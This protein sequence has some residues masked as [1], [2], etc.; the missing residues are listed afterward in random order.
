MERGV[1]PRPEIV[2]RL[3]R[4]VLAKLWINDP[5]PAARSREWREMLEKRFGTSSIPLYVTLDGDGREIGG[6]R[7]DF[8]GGGTDAFAADLAAFLDAAL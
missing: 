3:E 4:F 1:F 5:D 6:G 2:E 8:P 7:L